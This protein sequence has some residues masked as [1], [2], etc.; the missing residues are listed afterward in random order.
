MRSTVVLALFLIAAAASAET[1]WTAAGKAWWAH[2]RFLASDQLQGRLVGTKGYNAAA[3]YVVNQFERA[4]LAPGAGSSYSQSV[5]FV[6]AT[7]DEPASSLALVRDG[8][9]TPAILG[10]EALLRWASKPIPDLE[11]PL[12]FAGYGLNIPEAGYSDLNESNLRS[13]VV[14]Y[15]AEVQPIYRATFAPTTLPPRS[16]PKP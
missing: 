4:G 16:A 2:V 14:V 1:D 6:K 9:A 3:D 11:A 5:E 15:L 8:K 10:D 7:L 13:A 12:V